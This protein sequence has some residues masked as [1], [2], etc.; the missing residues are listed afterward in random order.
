MTCTLYLV[1]ST[2][3]LSDS[4]TG[5]TVPRSVCSLVSLMFLLPCLLLTDLRPVSALSLLCSL[6]HILIRWLD[7][8]WH[9]NCPDRAALSADC[10]QLTKLTNGIKSRQQGGLYNLLPF[11]VLWSF[12]SCCWFCCLL[13][14]ATHRHRC[15]WVFDLSVMPGVQHKT[16]GKKPFFGH[17]VMFNHTFL[18]SLFPDESKF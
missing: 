13:P 17:Q 18:L 15:Y 7:W 14:P 16:K 6:A 9:H 4:L 8:K 12:S 10:Y 2:S 3:L 5:M 11:S 1:V